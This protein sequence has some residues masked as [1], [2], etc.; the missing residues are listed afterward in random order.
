M[1]VFR[2]TLNVLKLNKFHMLH[3]TYQAYDSIVSHITKKVNTFYAYYQFF[4]IF[5]TL[6]E[7]EILHQ[8][9]KFYVIVLFFHHFSPIRQIPQP[10]LPN[11]A[12]IIL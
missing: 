5:H 12:I 6:T 3:A 4:Q 2:S 1:L 8:I 7:I 9:L 11:R 10:L